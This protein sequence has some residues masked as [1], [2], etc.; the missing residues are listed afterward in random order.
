MRPSRTRG[1][2]RLAPQSLTRAAGIIKLLGHRERLMLL[3]ALVQGEQ[4]VSEL[5]R[6][7]GLA[8][9]ICSQHLR[10]LRALE[11]VACRKDGQNV[12]YRVIEPR[13]GRIL[14]CICDDHRPRPRRRA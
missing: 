14:D 4:T 9:P 10:R 1:L 5:C 11:V 7:S 6:V 2:A 3:E 13:V 8:Q 12:Y